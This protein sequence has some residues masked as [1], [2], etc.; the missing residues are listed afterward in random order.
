MASAKDF[1]LEQAVELCIAS[2][3][4]GSEIDSDTQGLSS[5]EE[6]ELDDLLTRQSACEGEIE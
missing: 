3:Q 5:G 6:E 4:S 2:D 1:T